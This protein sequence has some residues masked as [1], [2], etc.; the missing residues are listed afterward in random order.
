MPLELSPTH[1]DDRGTHDHRNKDGALSEDERQGNFRGRA[2]ENPF[3]LA[4]QIKARDKDGN[5]FHGFTQKQHNARSLTVGQNTQNFTHQT[6]QKIKSKYNQKACGRTA[7]HKRKKHSNVGHD[8]EFNA[9]AGPPKQ[10]I[11]QMRALFQGNGDTAEQQ[12]R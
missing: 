2:I 11:I 12:R 3:C 10:H 6:A 8:D 5:H 1:I 7:H 4:H 9:N